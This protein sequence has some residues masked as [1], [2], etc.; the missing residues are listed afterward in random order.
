MVVQKENSSIPACLISR[1]MC[2]LECATPEEMAHEKGKCE[3]NY[4]SPVPTG[5]GST[6]WVRPGRSHSL[7]FCVTEGAFQ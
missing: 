5:A 7:L 4:S 6:G 1:R 3:M 2:H